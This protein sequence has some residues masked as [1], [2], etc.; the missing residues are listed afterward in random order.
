[1]KKLIVEQK[2]NQAYLGDHTP[3]V[4]PHLYLVVQVVNAV[5]PKIRDQLTVDELETYCNSTDWTVTIK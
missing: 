1:M 4:D 5:N 3:D 2:L